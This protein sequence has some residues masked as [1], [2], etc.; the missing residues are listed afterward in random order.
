MRRYAPGEVQKGHEV[1]PACPRVLRYVLA[2]VAAASL[3]TFALA[4]W[5]KR[6]ARRGRGRIP[7]R[8]LLGAAL[9]GGS[10][11]LVLAMLVVRHKTRKPSFLAALVLVLVAQA[12]VLWLV[13]R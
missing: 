1:V 2:W 10:P 4:V 12:A 5:D 3:A 6:Q 7:E 13:L 8:V 9:L 11:G